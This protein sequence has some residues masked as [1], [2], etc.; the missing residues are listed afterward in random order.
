MIEGIH[1]CDVLYR[2][3]RLVVWGYANSWTVHEVNLEGRIIRDFGWVSTK[4][5]AEAM[6]AKM[7]GPCRS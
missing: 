2:Q 5:Q 1:R 6:L 3:R 4:D 7:E